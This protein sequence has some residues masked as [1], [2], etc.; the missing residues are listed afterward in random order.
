MS[1]ELPQVMI[2]QMEKLGAALLSFA[3]E[4]RDAPLG[5]LEQ[6][7]PESVRSLLPRLL[8]VVLQT[9]ATNLQPRLSQLRPLCPDCGRRTKVQSWRPR[10]VKTVCGPLNFERPWYVC[11]HY[12]R[13]FSPVDQT[14]GLQ[15]R[16]RLSVGL[17]EW[18]IGSGATTSFAEAAYWLEKLTGL[19]VSAETVRQQTEER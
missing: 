7:V 13:G 5:T 16:G 17:R 14:L 15:P 2:A 19:A 9:S 4:H 3:K 10:A 8:E 6:A 18:L 11:S 1:E 12:Q